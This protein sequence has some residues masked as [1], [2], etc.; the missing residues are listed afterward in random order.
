MFK[1]CIAVAILAC[2]LVYSHPS[3]GKS[4]SHESEGQGGKG[5]SG[6]SSSENSG[7]GSSG[8]SGHSSSGNSGHS[9]G[10][11]SGHGSSGHSGHSSGGSAGKGSSGSSGHNSGGSGG[12]GSSGSSGHSSGGSSGHSSGGSGGKGSSGSSGNSSGGS[13]GKGSSGSSGHSSG[14]GGGKGGSSGGSIPATPINHFPWPGWVKNNKTCN[15]SIS[16]WTSDTSFT[17]I[18]VYMFFHMKFVQNVTG[19]ECIPDFTATKP[20]FWQKSWPWPWP[21]L[22]F[23]IPPVKNGTTTIGTSTSTTA[24]TTTIASTTT[25]TTTTTAADTAETS[26]LADYGQVYNNCDNPLASTRDG[27]SCPTTVGGEE[28]VNDPV[29]FED[30]SDE[31][32]P[33][34]LNAQVLTVFQGT[35]STADDISNNYCV[36]LVVSYYYEKYG[37]YHPNALCN[38]GDHSTRSV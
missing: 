13:G 11:S 32:S 7:H 22:L 34:I 30:T 4:S 8:S 21:C 9:S 27:F 14:G 6:H 26:G 20:S 16:S 15:G 23:P 17:K 37:D 36:P 5:S 35:T 1:A 19:D 24:S 33:A 3:G 31:A 38:N 2:V 10:G 12:K 28:V 25:P 29:D 18:P